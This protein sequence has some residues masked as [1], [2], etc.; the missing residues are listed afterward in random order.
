MFKKRELDLL[1]GEFDKLRISQSTSAKVEHKRDSESSDSEDQRELRSGAR[2]RRLPKD[3]PTTN[4]M[5]TT[6][7]NTASASAGAGAGP[8]FPCR[9]QAKTPMYDTVRYMSLALFL[10]GTLAVACRAYVTIGR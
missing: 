1:A 3:T 4:T 6:P 5:S 10:A 9:K 2:H 8:Q 7:P